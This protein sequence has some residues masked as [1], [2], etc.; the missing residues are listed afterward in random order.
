MIKPD[1]IAPVERA[2]AAQAG[3]APPW[4]AAQVRRGAIQPGQACR[5]SPRLAD[6][7]LRLARRGSPQ[8]LQDFFTY[9]PA[10]GLIHVLLLKDSEHWVAFFCTQAQ[11]SVQDIAVA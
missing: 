9:K 4:G 6:G 10:A 7:H 8:D 5:P 3:P 1:V 2:G 11:A